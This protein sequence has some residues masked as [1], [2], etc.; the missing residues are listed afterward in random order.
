MS[1]PLTLGWPEPVVCPGL[2]S[3]GLGG[4]G[5]ESPYFEYQDVG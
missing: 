2:A 4:V 1:L 3:E 5:Q